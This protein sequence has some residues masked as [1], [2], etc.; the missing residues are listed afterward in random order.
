MFFRKCVHERID[1]IAAKVR[2][3]PDGFL[4]IPDLNCK[5][6]SD[7][8]YVD[9]RPLSLDFAEAQLLTRKL[10]KDYSAN[11]RLPTLKEDYTAFQ[12]LN[13]RK[14]TRYYEWKAEYLDGSFLMV[15]PDV[16][17][18]SNPRR[19]DFCS[20]NTS[21]VEISGC[22]RPKNNGDMFWIGISRDEYDRAAFVSSFDEKSYCVGAIPPLSK[23]CLG[24]RLLI[25]E[26]K[27]EK[28]LEKAIQK[29]N[30]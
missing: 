1:D 8:L 12:K 28:E 6:A 5:M 21:L 23:D 7:N 25:D 22:S 2:V 9:G 19:Y 15:N 20:N 24:F 10:S 29:T 26:N 11:I 13:K 27:T 17:S 16:R 3:N 4:E 18:V 30:C 14:E